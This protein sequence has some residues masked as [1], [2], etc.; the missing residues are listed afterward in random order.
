MKR[1]LFGMRPSGNSV[2]LG[3]FIAEARRM[4]LRLLRK[5]PAVSLIEQQRM[6]LF[7]KFE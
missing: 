4:G 2:A 3:R 1:R 7:E 6:L 5:Y